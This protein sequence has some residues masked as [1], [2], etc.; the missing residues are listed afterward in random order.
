MEKYRRLTP[1]ERY[2]IEALKK[3]HL[4]LRDIASVLER[5]PSTISRELKRNCSTSGYYAFKAQK[6]AVARR[7]LIGPPKVICSQI[8]KKIKKLLTSQQ[9]SPEQMSAFLKRQNLFVSPET[10]YKFIFSEHRLGGSL[11]LN[12]RRH[13]HCRMTRKASRNYKNSGIRVNQLWIAERPKVVEERNRKGDFER[14]TVLGARGAPVLLTIVDRTTRFTRIAKISGINAEQAHQATVRLLRN[15]RVHTITNDNGAEFAFHK[16]T[17]KLLNTKIYFNDPYSSW[18]RGT[19]ENTNGLIRQY[20]PK[21]HDFRLVSDKEIKQ[22]QDKLNSRPRKCLG[23]KT[24]LEVE[25]LLSRVL[26]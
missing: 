14:D 4:S 8:E 13:R 22:I 20:Y 16:K 3:S 1:M 7:N 25:R 5:S 18:Q 21:G 9:L 11:Y 24:P 6:L 17:A 12:L 2:Q 15:S 23:F 26:R 10:I 19:N